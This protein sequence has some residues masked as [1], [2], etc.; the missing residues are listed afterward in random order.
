MPA[1][2][3]SLILIAAGAILTFAV[4]TSVGAVSLSTIGVILMCVGGIGLLMSLLFMMSFSPFAR[5]NDV[6]HVHHV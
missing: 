6:D 2:G 5:T 4:T 3:I 1:L